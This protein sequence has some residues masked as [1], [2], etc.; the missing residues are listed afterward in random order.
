MQATAPPESNGAGTGVCARPAP[1]TVP[2]RVPVA[3]PSKLESRGSKCSVGRCPGVDPADAIGTD[4]EPFTA[5]SLSED[6]ASGGA[7]TPRA[8]EAFPGPA[9]SAFAT[10]V[11]DRLDVGLRLP[12]IDVGST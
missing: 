5:D 10:I 12:S 3:E 1:P 11:A 6:R 8:S 9:V 7:P 2:R 4:V